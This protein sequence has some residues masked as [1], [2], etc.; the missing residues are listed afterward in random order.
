[1]QHDRPWPT[2]D[3]VVTDER[4]RVLLIRRK[5]EPYKDCYALPGGFMEVGETTEQCARRELKEE[6]GIVAGDLRL[7]GVYSGPGRDPRHHTVT[8]AYLTAVTGQVPRAAD[9]AATAE[10]VEMPL[11]G[12]LAFDHSQILADAL[13]LL[14]GEKQPRVP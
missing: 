12:R 1:M 11:K 2:T 4:G 5:N 6:T 10:F 9:D 8:I 3:C 7:I 14:G 13:R